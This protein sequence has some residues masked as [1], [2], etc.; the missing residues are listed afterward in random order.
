[1][2]KIRPRNFS[3]YFP[4]VTKGEEGE[5]VE[6]MFLDRFFTFFGHKYEKKFFQK[7]NIFFW[8]Q[9]F[10]G[11]FSR[12]FNWRFR[13]FQSGKPPL[14]VSTKLVLTSRANFSTRTSANS[15]VGAFK[16]TRFS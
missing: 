1:M 11:R 3:K 12:A 2:P 15:R 14:S 4:E 6:K 9:N 13:N 16:N 10:F 7:K 5:G 8:T